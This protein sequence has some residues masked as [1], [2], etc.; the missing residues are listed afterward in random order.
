MQ[1]LPRHISV[2]PD[3]NRRWA[4]KHGLPPFE[5]HRRG[6][7]N[8]RDISESALDMGIEFFTF[9]AASEDNLLKRNPLEVNFLVSLLCKELENE[10]TLKECQK[11]QV[12]VKIPGRWDEIL[13]NE[14]LLRAITA[15]ER[16]TR[17]FRKHCLTLLFGYDGRCEMVEAIKDIISAD[18]ETSRKC[19]HPEEA[20]VEVNPDLV[21]RSL[22]ASHLPL[23]D[24]EIRTGACEEGPNWSHNS[25]GFMM[26]LAADAKV[27]SP[28]TLWPDFTVEMF[29]Q[30][31]TDFSKT[32]RR[33][34][35]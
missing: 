13:K 1:E 11:R 21:K 24:L 15:I 25:S 16:E 10:R 33:F 3:G 9:W 14:R 5:G 26:W 20:P 34:G 22:W 4:A 29:R 27:F 2:I 19:K 31:L 23:V 18:R 30:A 12:M 8:F 17:L 6:I 32:P 7:Q 35:A 28:P